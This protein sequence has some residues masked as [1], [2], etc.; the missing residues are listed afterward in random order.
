MP[1]TP[2]L[3]NFH[4][5]DIHLKILNREQRGDFYFREVALVLDQ[6]GRLVDF[7]RIPEQR[8]TPAGGAA[9]SPDWNPFFTAAGL[10]VSQFQSAEPLWTS[11]G[12]SDLRTV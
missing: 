5:A 4:G 12:A 7:E 3:E 9:P 11:L 1:L 6:Q 2:T 8:F 10:D